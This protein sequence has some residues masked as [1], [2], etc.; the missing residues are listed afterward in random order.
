MSLG[1]GGSRILPHL[2]PDCAYRINQTIKPGRAVIRT[3][4]E[5]GG[6]SVLGETGALLGYLIIYQFGIPGIEVGN[7]G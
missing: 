6:D 3:E 4:S 7:L 5:R 2:G 1:C